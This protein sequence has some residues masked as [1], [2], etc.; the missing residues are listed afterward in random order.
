MRTTGWYRGSF[1]YYVHADHLN[2]PLKMTDGTQ[3]VVWDAVYN[4][5]GDVNAITGSAANSLRF[6]GQYFLIESGLHYNWYRHYD[7]TLG[8][9]IQPDPL[10]FVDGSNIYAYVKSNPTD[11][12]DPSGRY[13]IQG[14]L[15]SAAANFLIQIWSNHERGMSWSDAVDCVNW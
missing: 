5:F 13:W 7:A 14:A 6:P 11:I 3:A 8:R 12:V 1:L 9:Y 4:P 10:G 2:R 15:G